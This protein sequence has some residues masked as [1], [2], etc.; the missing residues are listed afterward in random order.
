MGEAVGYRRPNIAF[1]F[2]VAVLSV[3]FACS[4]PAW[5]T[6]YEDDNVGYSIGLPVGWSPVSAEIVAEFELGAEGTMREDPFFTPP[7][8]EIVG[9][10]LTTIAIFSPYDW[11][12]GQPRIPML[13]VAIESGH[14][15]ETVPDYLTIIRDHLSTSFDQ[16]GEVERLQC[17]GVQFG[18]IQLETLVD[19]TS[20]YAHLYCTRHRDYMLSFHSIAFRREE[21]EMM[22][23]MVC[24]TRLF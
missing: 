19:Q 6:T 7:E 8:A 16:V 24:S 11:T 4:N 15:S 2:F 22:R 10:N 23:S 5:H 17:P 20:T 18:F 21:L 3:Q 13:A 1:A 12:S 14:Q 9:A